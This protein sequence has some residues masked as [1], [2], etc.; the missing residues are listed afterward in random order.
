MTLPASFLRR[1]FGGSPRTV[2][3]HVSGT[4]IFAR[5]LGGDRQALAYQMKLTTP[6]PVAMVLPLPTAGRDE[7]T[8]EFVDLSALPDLFDRLARAFPEPELDLGLPKS[9]G[10]LRGGRQKLEVVPVGDFVASFV[11]TRGDFSR[12][13]ERF[14]LPDRVWDALP[15]YADWGFAVFQLARERQGKQDVH[16]MAFTFRT[17]EPAKLFFPTVHVHDGAVHSDAH[18]DHT[19]YAQGAALAE[20]S[21]LDAETVVDL[22]KAKGIVGGGKLAR[23][24]VHG[25]QRNDDHW[26]SLAEAAS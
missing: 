2:A 25:T 9:Q 4:R 7:S 6:V 13:D 1:L 3:V 20:V 5:A 18:F 22:V 26:F 12:L 8:L 16:P 10:I 23:K 19:L 14:R 11:P 17:R 21:S 24:G 15:R